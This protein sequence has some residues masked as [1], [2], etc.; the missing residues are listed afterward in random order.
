MLDADG[1]PKAFIKFE[2]FKIYFERPALRTRCIEAC[3]KIMKNLD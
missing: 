2:N 3:V 1:Y